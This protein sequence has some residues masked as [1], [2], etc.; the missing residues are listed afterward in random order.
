MVSGT[1][2]VQRTVTSVLVIDD[3]RATR[4][5]LKKFLVQSGFRVD[6]AD[7]GEEGLRLAL[8][9]EYGAILLDLVMPQPDGLAVLRQISETAPNLQRKIIIL[10]GYPHQAVA[11]DN[12]CAILIKPID[13]SQAIHLVKRCAEVE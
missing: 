7:G 10:T 5:L 11:I 13:I 2:E 1:I 6:L 3:D 4:L 12:I 9:Q 8:S